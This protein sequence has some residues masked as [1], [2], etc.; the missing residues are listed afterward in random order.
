MLQTTIQIANA[1][2]TSS[3]QLIG[4]PSAVNAGES[5]QRSAAESKGRDD[6]GPVNASI[7][8]SMRELRKF[9]GAAGRR[10]RPA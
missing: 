3:N 2:A 1:K 10:P 7:G 8:V 9:S 4:L 5:A 6:N